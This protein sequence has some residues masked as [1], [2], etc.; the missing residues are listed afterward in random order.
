LAAHEPQVLPV[1]PVR[2][3]HV[4]P[5]MSVPLTEAALLLQFVALLQATGAHDGYPVKFVAHA[6]QAAPV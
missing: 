3:V 4:Q 1:N 6:S 2:H 5:L